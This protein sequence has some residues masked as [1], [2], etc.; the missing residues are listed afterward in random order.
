MQKQLSH[1]IRA[2][3]SEESKFEQ[4]CELTRKVKLTKPKYKKFKREEEDSDLSSDELSTM[5]D[6]EH[7]VQ[8]K[9][10]NNKLKDVV[11]QTYEPEA[12]TT[13]GSDK[14]NGHRTTEDA[15]I[16]PNAETP[17][18]RLERSRLQRSKKHP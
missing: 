17:N 2:K 4:K 15:D 13:K 3:Y 12:I 14:R 18:A 5:F 8:G 6:E 7:E 11:E 10:K 9:P 1:A 16:A